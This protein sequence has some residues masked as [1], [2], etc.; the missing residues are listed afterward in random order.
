MGSLSEYINGYRGRHSV[1]N[2][3][4]PRYNTRTGSLNKGGDN[5]GPV[6]VYGVD[7]NLEAFGRIMTSDPQMAGIFRKYIRN[8][9]KDAR[10]KLS[11]DVK[12]YMKSDPRKAYKA[13][14][15]AVYRR[16]FGGNV[17]ILSP[18]KAGNMRL[19]EPPRR[20]TKDQYG[21]G[22]NR[23]KRS[24]RTTD[25]MSYQGGDRW[26]VLQWLNNGTRERFSGSG[27]NGNTEAQYRAFVDRTGGRGKRGSIAARNWFGPRSYQELQA[28][29]ANIDAMIDNILQGILY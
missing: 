29:A 11:Q 3:D 16:I 25:M 10:K 4:S 15:M 14:K 19:Y 6:Q 5:G 24:D 26:M 13:I 23:M 27:R 21:R 7:A 12:S 20:G 22:G 8:V 2:Y 18:R 1:Y 17:S 9:L 28:A